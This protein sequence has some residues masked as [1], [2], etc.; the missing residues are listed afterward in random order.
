ME[1]RDE[2][3]G[4]FSP[5]TVHRILITL[6]FRAFLAPLLTWFLVFLATFFLEEHIAAFSLSGLN[7]LGLQDRKGDK[8]VRNRSPMHKGLL[9]VGAKVQTKPLLSI[10]G[11]L[12]AISSVY[13]FSPLIFVVSTSDM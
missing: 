1:S 11:L 3:L 13:S 6:F 2:I 10:N 9:Q 4:C 5:I 12:T 7:G 8:G